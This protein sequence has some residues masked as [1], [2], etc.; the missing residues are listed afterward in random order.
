MSDYVDHVGIY[1]ENQD[2][3]REQRELFYQKLE[4]VIPQ[5]MQKFTQILSSYMDEFV[6]MYAGHVP[7]KL[8]P[9]LDAPIVKI[10][11]INYEISVSLDT[12]PEQVWKYCLDRVR[13]ML[14]QQTCVVDMLES[15][16]KK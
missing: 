3:T 13:Y 16:L 15:S 1:I 2:C 11:P 14:H 9:T 12:P 8:Y 5:D 4:S 6:E 7:I 10:H